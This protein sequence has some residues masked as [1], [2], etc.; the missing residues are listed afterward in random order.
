MFN[1]TLTALGA[2]ALGLSLTASAASAQPYGK[3]GAYSLA[4]AQQASAA[5]KSHASKCDCTMMQGG[6]AM[7]EQCM[8]MAAP[9]K[10]DATR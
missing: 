9:A 8:S 1:H 3:G 7:H 6:S 5:T 2:L 10:P 4:P